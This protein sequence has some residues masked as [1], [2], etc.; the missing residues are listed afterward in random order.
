MALYWRNGVIGQRFYCGWH[1]SYWLF[2]DFF[3]DPDR[4]TE[5]INLLSQLK[6]KHGKFAVSGNHDFITGIEMFHKV[7][8]A[9][10]FRVLDHEFANECGLT[11]VGVP[12]EMAASFGEKAP[13]I[14]FIK[15]ITT[16]GPIVFLKH[17]PTLFRRAASF[18]ASLQLSGLSHNGQLPPW[19]LVVALRYSKY[20]HGLH[21]FKDS[22]IYTSSGTGVWG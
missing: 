19:G 9:L 4:I 3:V 15:T 20:A 5:K 14:A 8:D 17:R 1:D 21:R 2:S 13:D 12:D 18:G 11:F 6:A 10:G 22:F 7:C 16:D